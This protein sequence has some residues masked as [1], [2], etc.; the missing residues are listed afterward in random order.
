M[1]TIEKKSVR[2]GKFVDTKHVDTII[3]NYKQKRWAQNSERLGKEDSLSVWFSVEDI[4]AFLEKAKEH[5]GDGVRFYFGAYDEQFAEKPVYA[6]RQT[7]VMV[8][9]KEKETATGTT[10]KDIYF[11]TEKGSSILAY[12]FGCVCPPYCANDNGRIGV[13]IIDKGSE[14]L[15]V[16]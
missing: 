6:G 12:N 15:V 7:L 5:G 11:N 8:A 2:A 14:G 1:V 3:K 4:E 16:S 10:N 9:T 13:T